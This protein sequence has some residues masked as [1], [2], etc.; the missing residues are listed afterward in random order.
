MATM[1]F[2]IPEDVKAR[3]NELFADR[4]KSAV[5]AELLREAIARE[6]RRRVAMAAADEIIANQAQAPRA[7]DS[8]IQSLRRAGR[9]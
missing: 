2:S 7:S 5:V 4:N 1:N 9:G 6:E 3:F 8:E